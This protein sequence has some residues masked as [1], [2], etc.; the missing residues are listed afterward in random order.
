MPKR[1]VYTAVE[2]RMVDDTNRKMDGMTGWAEFPTRFT[3]L[4]SIQ[5]QAFAVDR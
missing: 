3:T 5:N 1:G 4:E 2:Q